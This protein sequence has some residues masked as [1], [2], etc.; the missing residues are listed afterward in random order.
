MQKR[1][2]KIKSVYC[3]SSFLSSGSDIMPGVPGNKQKIKII[4]GN[5]E[6]IR[7]MDVLFDH[8]SNNF[9]KIMGINCDGNKYLTSEGESLIQNPFLSKVYGADV[10]INDIVYVNSA[11]LSKYTYDNK[12]DV[13]VNKNDILQEI[14][15]TKNI[16]DKKET[17]VVFLL[18]L[19]I[20][21]TII[22]EDSEFYYLKENDKIEK[23][24]C[25]RLNI[26]DYEN[27]M[28]FDDISYGWNDNV[29]HKLKLMNTDLSDRIQIR[30][31][32]TNKK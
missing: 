24:F 28:Q 4:Y 27:L 3:P 22:Y 13:T 9:Y 6:N 15:I 25:V 21:D 23:S 17:N 19:N 29:F 14:L 11:L 8:I 5:L 31:S 32:E 16:T 26:T 18:P 30:E 7:S 12:I 1:T 20:F 2:L 10:R